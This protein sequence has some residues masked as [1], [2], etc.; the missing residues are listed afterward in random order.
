MP[1]VGLL[2]RVDGDDI[3]MRERRDRLGLAPESFNALL[4]WLVSS[5]T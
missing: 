3:G 1:G 4:A 2:D 5:A